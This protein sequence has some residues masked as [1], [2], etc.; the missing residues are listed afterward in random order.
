[1]QIHILAVRSRW[2]RR[3]GHLGNVVGRVMH[4]RYQ[5]EIDGS[6]PTRDLSSFHTVR[7]LAS[8]AISRGRNVSL[9]STVK[10][11]ISHMRCSMVDST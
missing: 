2:S 6:V 1:M 3:R 4:I 8:D 7:C 5:V 10:R 11:A 9:S